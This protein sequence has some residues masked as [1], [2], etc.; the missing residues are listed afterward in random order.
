[1]AAGPLKLDRLLAL[2]AGDAAPSE[3]HVTSE[4][5]KLDVHRRHQVR[6]SNISGRSAAGRS[7]VS[8]CG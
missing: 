7:P 2:P 6:V 5:A 8:Y 3:Q 1:V 4:E